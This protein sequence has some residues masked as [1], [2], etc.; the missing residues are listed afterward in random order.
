MAPATQLAASISEARASSTSE[1]ELPAPTGQYGIG[2]K[3]YNWVDH[4]RHELA[5]KD[6]PEFRQVIVQVW[7][8]AGDHSRPAAPY[9]PMLSSYR[10]VWPASQVDL[11]RRTRTHS[12]QNAKPKS[13]MRFAVVLLSHGWEGTRSEYTSV[14]EDYMGQIALPNGQCARHTASG[15]WRRFAG[16]R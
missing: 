5:L 1:P 13:G 8:P 14:A 3:V 10:H 12:H 11:A 15:R 4:S 6:P 16:G 9:V 7:Y 2:T